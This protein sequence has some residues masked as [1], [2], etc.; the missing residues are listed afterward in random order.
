MC[1]S[2]KTPQ[3]F[4]EYFGLNINQ[5]KIEFLDIY[6]NN[7]IP[8]FL[9]PYG[10][11]AMNSKW[12]QDCENNIATYFQY[13]ID[14]IRNGDKKTVL[15]LLNA[16]HEV[17]EIALG[18]SLGSPSGRGI[19][20]LQA[21][22]IKDAFENSEAAKS[23]DIK[24]IAD[25]A[26]LIPGINRDKIS[27]ITAN[28]LKRQ[29]IEFT[30]KIC[31]KYSIPIQR[32]AINN[33]FDFGRFDFVSYYSELP[34]INGKAKI[35]LPI[36]GVRQ[37][38]EL[39]RDKYYRNFVLEFLR[40]EHC[41]AGDSLSTVLKNGS[42]IV[43]IGDL[44]E[45]YPINTDFLYKFSKEHPQILEK[46]KTEL[47]RTANKK[48]TRPVLNPL[49]KVLTGFERIKILSEV[50]PGNDDATNF[51]KISYNNLIYIFGN[52][53]T[54]PNREREINEGRKRIDIVFDNNDNIG[55]FSIL[56]N[57]HHIQCPKIL[58]ECK[59]YGHE[60]GNPEIDQL[61]ARFNNQRGKFGLLLCR[62][63]S[64]RKKLIQRCKDAMY[65]NNGIII[66]LDDSDIS[67]LIKLKSDNNEIGIDN[68]M[69][70]K[71]DEL[72]M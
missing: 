38:P 56:N 2:I 28:I 42:V 72:I 44:K 4:S 25:C 61:L 27:D 45:K 21:S 19:G 51:H 32:V 55:F 15:K 39:S 34:V 64:D 70:K 14:S 33:T 41:H 20:P 10:I 60:V 24:D 59:N 40:A 50:K 11:S 48:G 62:S 37:D 69:S 16:L 53:L 8:L 36:S 65:G 29:L 31:E 26:I 66:V 47:R 68:Y 46:F 17:D 6:A 30:Q 3:K 54:N 13:L 7:D 5:D 49:V 22:Q 9:D 35:L 43:R 52:R 23:G 57:L 63:I 71:L 1:K 58:I 67:V 18:Y 12:S